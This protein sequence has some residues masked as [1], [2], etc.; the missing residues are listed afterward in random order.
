VT[1]LRWHKFSIADFGLE[2]KGEIKSEKGKIAVQNS[3]FGQG[4]KIKWLK[5]GACPCA[6][7]LLFII[8]YYSQR[9]PQLINNSV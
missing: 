6:C 2:K 3:K 8:P 7:P 9:G 1:F 5:I 4:Q